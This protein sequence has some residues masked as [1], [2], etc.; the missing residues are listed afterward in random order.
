M[1]DGTKL[2]LGAMGLI[3]VIFVCLTLINI[4]GH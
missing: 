4:F 2:V 1:N 3:A